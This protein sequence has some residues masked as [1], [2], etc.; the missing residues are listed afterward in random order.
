VQRALWRHGGRVLTNE[1]R[2]EL[3]AELSPWFDRFAAGEDVC[4][5]CVDA[6]AERASG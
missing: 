4:F 1:F 3:K 6:V 5:Q 2:A